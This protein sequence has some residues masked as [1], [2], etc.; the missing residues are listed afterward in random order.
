MTIH[1]NVET[2]MYKMFAGLFSPKTSKPDAR[3]GQDSL[4][5]LEKRWREGL[6]LFQKTHKTIHLQAAGDTIFRTLNDAHGEHFATVAFQAGGWPRP[7]ERDFKNPPVNGSQAE[8]DTLLHDML[9]DIGEA[10]KPWE[11]IPKRKML[12]VID[13]IL[14]RRN[15]KNSPFVTYGKLAGTGHWP[16]DGNV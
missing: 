5:D 7:W 11:N 2:V 15:R 10:L 12:T 3:K 16:H 6:D 4:S 13:Q 9:T 8:H 14:I 1:T